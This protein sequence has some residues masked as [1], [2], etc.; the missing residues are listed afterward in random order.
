MNGDAAFFALRSGALGEAAEILSTPL[1]REHPTAEQ[2]A[3]FVDGNLVG[4]EFQMVADHLTS[5]ER[6]ALTVDDLRAFRNRIAS[7]LDLEYHPAPAAIP[8]EGWWH[9]TAASL[10]VLFGR[11][12]GLAFGSALTV[13]LL[14]VTGWFV[15]RTLPGREPKQEAVVSTP[16]STQPAPALPA[17]QLVAQIDDGERQVT[18]DEEGRLSGADDLPPTYRE[19]AEESADQPADRNI[20][21]S[22]RTRPAAKRS[23]EYR[24]TGGR[25]FRDR[26]CW[27]CAGDRSSDFPLVADGR[28]D[29][30][31]R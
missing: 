3:G 22:Q 26:A 19:H 28:H 17:P 23:D 16:P 5:C 27:E 8:T 6:C 25:V 15:W 31:F 29:R 12:P 24:Q 14:A 9:R 11:S 18:L 21:S 13:A 1:A 2:T 20:T 10:S 7:S 30:L 4:D